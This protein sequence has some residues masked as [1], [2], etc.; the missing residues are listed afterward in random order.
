M[1]IAKL[2]PVGL[3]ERIALIQ[4]ALHDGL[5]QKGWTNYY[6]YERVY[7]N[8]QKILNQTSN[9][10]ELYNGNNNYREVYYNDKH[11]AESY[12]ITPN[13]R[14]VESDYVSVSLGVIFQLDLSKIYPDIDH[15]ADEEAHNDVMNVLTKI[16]YIGNVTEIVTGVENVY[17]GLDT[18][19]V[20]LTDMQP[21]HVFRINFTTQY[22][23]KCQ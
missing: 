21:C 10:P 17:S 15:R 9:I 12:F 7:I 3:D 20:Q 19:S 2:N 8:P 6:A 13:T 11:N 5:E 16:S 18:D 14:S 23:S 4:K 1:I 22:L